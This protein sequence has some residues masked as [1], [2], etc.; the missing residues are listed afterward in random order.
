MSEMERS[1]FYLI[2]NGG[3]SFLNFS[4]GLRITYTSTPCACVRA[5]YGLNLAIYISEIARFCVAARKYEI[6]SSLFDTNYRYYLHEK[7]NSYPHAD[8]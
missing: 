4:D 3:F 2:H 7:I 1:L 5:C 6:L 8:K